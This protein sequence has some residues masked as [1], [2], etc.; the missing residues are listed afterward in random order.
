[1]DLLAFIIVNPTTGLF[2]VNA[3]ARFL[4][5]TDDLDAATR[6]EAADA[7]R[8]IDYDT[9]GAAVAELQSVEVAA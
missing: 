3:D 9:D 7:D 8:L 4:L 5:W 2:V 1:M 6:F